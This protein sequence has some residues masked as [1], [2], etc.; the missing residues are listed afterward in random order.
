MLPRLPRLS[1]AANAHALDGRATRTGRGKEEAWA[2][3]TEGT[4]ES[5]RTGTGE[6]PVSPGK[7][8]IKSFGSALGI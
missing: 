1:A 7:Q 3:E 8:S 6:K 2:E 4:E 5:G